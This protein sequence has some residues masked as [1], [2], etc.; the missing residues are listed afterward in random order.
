MWSILSSL[1]NDSFSYALTPPLHREHSYDPHA[2]RPILA[3][4]FPSYEASMNNSSA[5]SIINPETGVAHRTCLPPSPSPVRLRRERAR[6]LVWP[7]EIEGKVTC[8]LFEQP[9]EEFIL[10]F[11]RFLRVCSASISDRRVEEGLSCVSFTSG[12][13][14][15][16]SSV[17]E[18]PRK[19]D[20]SR[21][22]I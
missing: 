21:R 22:I 5:Q 13:H 15:A 1:K 11:P 2:N 10:G 12:K 3:R 20:I 16:W 8:C 19:R 7:R 14:A 17:I 9:I 18:M 6:H 4:V